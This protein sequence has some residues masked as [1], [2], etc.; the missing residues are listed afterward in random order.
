M[1]KLNVYVIYD[2]VAEEAGP[3]FEAPNDAVAVRS[4]TATIKTA[5]DPSDYQ[6][7]CVGEVD[8]TGQVTL[9][10]QSNRVVE[11]VISPDRR[12]ATMG[13]ES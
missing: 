1:S 3:L 8:R 9:V 2:K 11:F 12:F 5:Y 10:A 4:A 6:L 7:L 13:A